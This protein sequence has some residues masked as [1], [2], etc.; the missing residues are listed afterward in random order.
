MMNNSLV[1]I[2]IYENGNKILE[3]SRELYSLK[4]KKCYSCNY[5]TIELDVTNQ[6]LLELKDFDYNN[7]VCYI[8]IEPIESELSKIIFYKITEEEEF[9]LS[10][11]NPRPNNEYLKIMNSHKSNERNISYQIQFL[12]STRAKIIYRCIEDCFFDHN[13]HNDNN[14]RFECVMNL[15]EY[16]SVYNLLE[17]YIKPI[18]ILNI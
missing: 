1:E 13:D 10:I 18:S 15:N 5:N 3:C 12:I 14:N 8:K 9:N 7:F 2:N 11:I 6:T 17:Y 4:T 16:V